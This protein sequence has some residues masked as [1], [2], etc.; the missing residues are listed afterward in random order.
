P[1]TVNAL[2][3]HLRDRL[4]DYMIPA[5][6][7]ELPR[8]PLT[9]NGKVD[10]NTLP[11]P[12][13][14]E[15]NLGTEYVPPRTE[16][17]R[18]LAAIW[19]QVLDRE[20]IGVHDDFFELGGHSLTAV[21]LVTRILQSLAVDVA[22]RDV[23][24]APTIA[25]LADVIQARATTRF[26]AIEPIAAQ[27]HYDLS[28]AQR[29]VWVLSQFE[30]T[31]A[32]YNVPASF[33]VEGAF[34]VEA[35]RQ[36]FASVIER[37]EILRTVFRSIDG[38]PRQIVRPTMEPA[39]SCIDLRREHDP[40]ATV[41]DVIRRDA[42]APFNLGEGPLIRLHLLRTGDET[43]ILLFNM[44][45]IITD[46]WS[47]DILMREVL[48]LYE[49]KVA[50]RPHQL[51]PL[52][53]QYKDYAAWQ[54]AM[55]SD[56]AASRSRDYWRE[57]LAGEIP[58]LNLPTDQ[59]RPAHKTFNGA[60]AEFHFDPR[61][62]TEL[63][64]LSTET[65]VS[66]FMVL[67]AAVNVL[68][69]RYTNQNDI[70]IGSPIAGRDHIDLEDQLGL[71]I[72][73]LAMRSRI[74]GDETFAAFLQ[75]VQRTTTTAYEHQN[76][77]FDKLVD[78]LE[79]ARDVSRSPLFDV[80]VSL[81]ST[82]RRTLTLPGGRATP[83]KLV[84]LASKFDLTFIFTEVDESLNLELEYNTDL[85]D[86]ARMQRLWSHLI[87]L[88]HDVISNPHYRI[89]ALTLLSPQEADQVLRGFNGVA[90]AYPAATLVDLFEQQ[91]ERTPDAIAVVSTHG[92]L[93]YGALNAQA[94]RLAHLL[95]EQYHVGPDDL[96]GVLLDRSADMIV[97][98]L[99]V[100][101]AGG[102]YIPMD[103]DY[104]DHRIAYTVD[105]S[106]CALVVSE[107]RFAEQLGSQLRTP[108]IDIA[109]CQARLDVPTH[110]PTPCSTGANLAYVIYT[111]GS[112]GQPKGCAVTHA[113]V[114]RL[115]RNS[116]FPYEVSGDD[117]WIMAHSYCFDFSVWEMY[118]ALLYG[119][120][121][122][123]PD[124]IDVQD[125]GRLLNLVKQH[126][127]TM[128][129]QTPGAFYNFIDEERRQS[130]RTL[131]QHLRS[132][133]FGGDRLDPV[134]LQPWVERYP[135]SDVQLVNMYGITETT[136]HVTFRE[137]GV[138]DVYSTAGLSNVGKPLP[139]TDV[140]ILDE[141]MQ[142]API[143]VP[144][145]LYVG[146]GGLARGYVNR[147]ALSAER[148][149][150]HPYR[151][152]ER[153]YKTGDLGRWQPDGSIEIWGRKDSQVKIRGFRIELGEIVYHLMA[154]A[155][156]KDAVVIAKDSDSGGKDLVAYIVGADGAAGLMANTFRDHLGDVLPGYMIPAYF[157]PLEGLP[158]T[159]NN[160]IDYQA[161]PDPSGRSLSPSMEFAS[162]RNETEELMADLWQ[163]FLMQEQVS[164]HDNFFALGGDSIKALQIVSSLHDHNVELEIRDFFA[165][166]TIAE[167]I[168]QL[169]HAE[170]DGP[171]EA[172]EGPAPLTA[173][174]TW[175]LTAYAGNHRHYNQ[176]VML[177]AP[178]RFDAEAVRAVLHC[179]QEHHDALR[180]TFRGVQG[181]VVQEV[182]PEGY[183]LAFDTVDL[184]QVKDA[185]R[186]VD[187]RAV[188]VQRSSDL[189]HGPLMRAV[190]FQLDD[191]DRLLIVIHHLGVD[192]VSW[193][194]L[195]QDFATAY[196]Q[197]LDG[198][199]IVLPK[200]SDA[201]SHWAVLIRDY[202]TSAQLLAELPY[203]QSVEETATD[204]LPYDFIR[205]AG[206]NRD[207]QV[208]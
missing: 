16:L 37:H 201:F 52:R 203:W 75:D 82:G 183:P 163:A 143:G 39:I 179:L 173:I 170:V 59:P 108:F 85:F 87:A 24:S 92:G 50:G 206:I 1:P 116:A 181:E 32:A 110:N 71:Y 142:P 152:G 207:T 54:H 7:V 100:L 99:G 175:F 31:S 164:I 185:G 171:Q 42:V 119:G 120:T 166:P 63:K 22:I 157:V 128:L 180:T 123:V 141:N 28:H 13:G 64:R 15:F 58:V 97:G 17:E 134:R 168:P 83:Y 156:I 199:A 9:A 27:E 187:R 80:M 41:E 135:F 192:G 165:W 132:V 6:F 106:A 189:E 26:V 29:R 129:N 202:S 84:S 117:V 33:V 3:A 154:H 205:P 103:T 167:L 191:G 174:Q 40:Y 115:L 66:L 144:G 43:H 20:S 182:V 74:N 184:R 159:A 178:E 88:L 121:L 93:T 34:N 49:C 112:T 137:I 2:R 162:P 150:P 149:I 161:L 67:L 51:R 198:E 136:V 47:L 113:N 18:Q 98:L 77:P 35:L 25:R 68:A 91:V 176:S 114:V 126:H 172:D 127:V 148:F 190:L 197:Y 107:S 111:S 81:Q 139:E 124:R 125:S 194:I 23:F 5:H 45:H 188:E 10:R 44:H 151:A 61:T 105:D 96:V 21:R 146:N 76:Y 94:N 12:S 69:Y 78:E 109:T 195:L 95:R 36:S 8:I 196:A 65:G 158:L 145:E 200:K 4:P 193:R 53:L 86:N 118:G 56:A 79:L 30:D 55:L 138:A 60:T 89:N 122:I 204:D 147:Q 62:T 160:K 72:N 90:A 169:T 155:E 48:H 70:I 104:P 140:F 19:Q 208:Y 133:I 73:T 102:A 153:L 101:K 186:E 131:H 46:A 57:Q 177:E 14:A 38:T 130:E 11:A